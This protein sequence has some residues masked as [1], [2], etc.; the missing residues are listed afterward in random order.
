MTLTHD[1]L[2]NLTQVRHP[3]GIGSTTLHYDLGG[4]KTSMDDP[5]LGRWHYAHDRQGRLT[6]QTDARGT[7]T[8]LYYNARYYDPEIGAFISPDTLV[9]RPRGSRTTLLDYN[10]YLYVRGRPLTMNDPSGHQGVGQVAFDPY[11]GGG[12][13]GWG[14]VAGMAGSAAGG[15]AALQ[16]GANAADAVSANVV[17]PPPFRESVTLTSPTIEI[18]PFPTAGDEGGVPGDAPTIGLSAVY[19][20]TVGFGNTVLA[21]PLPAEQNIPDIVYTSIAQDLQQRGKQV[22]GL[23]PRTTSGND[24]LFRA[25]SSGSVTHY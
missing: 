15:Y 25:D 13:G 21:D 14:P 16:L 5:D 23:F 11:N 1:L 4:R 7:T 3:N 10:R 19:Q 17:V 22:S 8:C 12:M 6:R 9:P 2:G 20:Q 18:A 24:L